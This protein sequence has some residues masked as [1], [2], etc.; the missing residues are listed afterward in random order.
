MT[1]ADRLKQAQAALFVG[2]ANAFQSLARTSQ[3]AAV[4][5]QYE[6]TAR[7][8]WDRAEKMWP[9]IESDL[10]AETDDASAINDIASYGRSIAIDPDDAGPVKSVEVS[11]EDRKLMDGMGG[12]GR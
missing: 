11:A 5:V 7:V 8:W 3:R 6:D 9:S 10:A 2:F 4:K 1:R 12:D